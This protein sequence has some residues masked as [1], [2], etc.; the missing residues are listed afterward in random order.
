M[1]GH[2][3]WRSN[4]MLAGRGT[5]TY[6]GALMGCWLAGAQAYALALSWDAGWQGNRHMRGRSDGMLAGTGTGIC[7]GAL[8]GMLAGR[9]TG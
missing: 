2:R 9:G 1:Y 3:R 8:M 6:V 7:V 4:G 5:G